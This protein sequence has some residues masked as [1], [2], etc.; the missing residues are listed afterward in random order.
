MRRSVEIRHD[1]DVIIFD[2]KGKFDRDLGMEDDLTRFME[3]GKR[4]FLLNISKAKLL[5]NG[6][7]GQIVSC[8]LKARKRKA[9]FKLLMPLKHHER[10]HLKIIPA[11]V[12]PEIF[13]NEQVALESFA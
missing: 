6:C 4:K 1:G 12:V 10:Y 8:F 9:E 11:E 2:L 3:A 13:D 5:S 7:T